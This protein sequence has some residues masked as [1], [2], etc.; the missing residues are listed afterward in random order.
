MDNYSKNNDALSY[1]VTETISIRPAT[2]IRLYKAGFKLIALS[3]ENNVI[4]YWTPI[5]D[6]PNYWT[7]ERLSSHKKIQEY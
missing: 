2:L 1:S 5:Y 7:A 3:A 4:E 6:D